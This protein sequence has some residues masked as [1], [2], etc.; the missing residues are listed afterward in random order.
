MIHLNF[1]HHYMFSSPSS[2]SIPIVT[3]YLIHWFA[4]ITG[5]PG[6]L[7]RSVHLL[8]SAPKKLLSRNLPDSMFYTCPPVWFICS[9]EPM[10][11]CYRLFCLHCN[12]WF[13]SLPYWHV[14]LVRVAP[15]FLVVL[16]AT[17]S[18][19]ATKTLIN[20]LEWM[21]GWMNEWSVLF[22]LRV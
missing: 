6:F 17:Y 16:G 11:N 10:Q 20:Y 19:P 21:D 2:I 4:V 13:V 15:A 7:T 22:L 8:D 9:K 14:S 5:L 3:F 12:S 18:I 1:F